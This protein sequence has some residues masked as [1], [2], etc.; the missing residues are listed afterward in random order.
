MQELPLNPQVWRILIEPPVGWCVLIACLAFVVTIYNV[1]VAYRLRQ[2]VYN[3]ARDI[4]M[5]ELRVN[6]KS[7]KGA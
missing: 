4:E 5:L 6:P 3:M 2:L 7:K 1:F